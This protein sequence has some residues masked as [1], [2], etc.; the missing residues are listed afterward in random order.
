MQMEIQQILKKIYIKAKFVIQ[1]D[2]V[3]RKGGI[4][5]M[6]KSEKYLGYRA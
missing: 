4:C 2:Y 1:L 6:G 3:E 5:R